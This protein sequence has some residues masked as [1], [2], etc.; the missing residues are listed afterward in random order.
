MAGY[1]FELFLFS[2][3]QQC[4]SPKMISSVQYASKYLDYVYRHYDSVNR[5]LVGTVLV[6]IVL[7]LVLKD[8]CTNANDH[9]EDP[10]SSSMVGARL[11]VLPPCSAEP[12]L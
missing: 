7:T 11:K 12:G 2:G 6:D 5:F 3:Q 1:G 9:L 8:L 10:A 4:C